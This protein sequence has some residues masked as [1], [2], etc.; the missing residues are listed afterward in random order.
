MAALQELQGRN[1]VHDKYR[2]LPETLDEHQSMVNYSDSWFL[3]QFLGVTGMWE[4]DD[5]NAP[6]QLR[7]T[8]PR[9]RG[10]M[11]FTTLKKMSSQGR[12]QPPCWNFSSL[13]V[14]LS[15]L[16]YKTGTPV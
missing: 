16:H 9:R 12:S 14:S 7:A 15:T 4:A 2:N 3:E 6:N 11:G 10:G 5:V 13:V 8:F 1:D